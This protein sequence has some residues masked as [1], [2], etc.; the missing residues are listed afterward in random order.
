MSN[1]INTQEEDKSIS[2]A[3]LEK[4]K[5]GGATPK[6]RWRFVVRGI[7][8]AAISVFVFVLLLFVVSLAS[9]DITENNILQARD[10]GWDGLGPLFGSLPWILFAII[11]VLII[12][13]EALVSRYSLAYRRPL[14]Y[15]LGAV[16]IVAIVGTIGLSQLHFHESMERFSNEQNLPV[17]FMYHGDMGRPLVNLHTGIIQSFNPD[18]F[19]MKN[20]FNEILSV[21]VSEQTRFPRGRDL[22]E[23]DPVLVIGPR[24]D[25]IIYAQGVRCLK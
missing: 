11:G 1:S 19:L 5:D 4:I 21:I 16:V 12:A 15:S 14:L 23:N 20:H 7:I 3:V 22:E 24:Q 18:G 10:F 8:W 9:F 6:P 17:T 2:N 13:V 25:M